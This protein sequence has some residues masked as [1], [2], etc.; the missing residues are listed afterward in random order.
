MFRK[1]G[2]THEAETLQRETLEVRRRILGRQHPDTLESMMILAG[3]LKDQRRYQEAEALL[4]ETFDLRSRVLGP[5]H[6]ATANIRYNLAC[7]LALGGRRDE[8]LKSL[9]DA[10]DNGL[11][12]SASASI[13]RDPDFKVLHGDPRFETIVAEAKKRTAK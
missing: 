4:R 6:P 10:L 5:R 12:E 1:A 11:S 3:I 9:R 2:R 7:N 8:A 13:E